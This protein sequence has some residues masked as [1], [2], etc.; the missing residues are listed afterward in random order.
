MRSRRKRARGRVFL[1]GSPR[2]LSKP[3]ASSTYFSR[4]LAHWSPR[5]PCS[6]KTRRILSATLDRFSF[7]GT[8]DAGIAREVFVTGYASQSE[9]EINARFDAMPGKHFDR[10]KANVVGLPT[11]QWRPAPSKATSNLRGPK[12]TVVKNMVMHGGAKGRVSMSSRIDA[13]RRRAGDVANMS[14]PEPLLHSPASCMPSIILTAF[15]G[16]ISRI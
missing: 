7:G 3:K 2:N 13:R 12:R 14:A 1:R 5:S 4:A 11:R 9:A 15:L 16:S 8:M 6:M 10:L